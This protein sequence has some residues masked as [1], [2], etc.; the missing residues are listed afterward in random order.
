MRT[1]KC[2][3]CS[4]LSDLAVPDDNDD[5][6]FEGFCDQCRHD[7]VLADYFDGVLEVLRKFGTATLN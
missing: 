7:K 6:D 3:D 2:S 1:A 5:D 4:V